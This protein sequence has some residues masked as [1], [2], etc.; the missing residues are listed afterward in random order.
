MF[1][2]QNYLNKK[3]IHRLKYQKQVLQKIGKTVFKIFQFK[4]K[5]NL[6]LKDK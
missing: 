2:I 6:K 3:C 1:N 5:I 4:M